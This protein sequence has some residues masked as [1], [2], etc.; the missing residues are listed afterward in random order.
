[1][2]RSDVEGLV[3]IFISLTI[4]LFVFFPV[5]YEDSKEYTLNAPKKTFDLD[6]N[7]RN[8]FH[9]VT[10]DNHL[11]IIYLGNGDYFTHHPDCSCYN[12]KA[13]AE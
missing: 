13:E 12:R 2:K 7:I 5:L 8:R 10:H 6:L 1:M 9:T 11:W 4:L 3:V